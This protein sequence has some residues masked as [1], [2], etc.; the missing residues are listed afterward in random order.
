MFLLNCVW[1]CA[2]LIKHDSNVIEV[3]ERKLNRG[4][5]KVKWPQLSW[6]S[7]FLITLIIRSVNEDFLAQKKSICRIFIY[8]RNDLSGSQTTWPRLKPLLM[9]CHGF[10]WLVALFLPDNGVKTK[11]SKYIHRV[12]HLNVYLW[13]LTYSMC[14]PIFLKNHNLYTSSGSVNCSMCVW[15]CLLWL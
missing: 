7:T 12:N 5:H 14:C 3:I 9:V 4:C 1:W 15:T 6:C 13:F 8:Q 2:F 11:T 10:L